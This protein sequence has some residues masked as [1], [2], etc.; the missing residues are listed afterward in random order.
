MHTVH[1]PHPPIAPAP[2]K[3]KNARDETDFVLYE[4]NEDSKL[5][6]VS[7]TRIG[8]PGAPPAAAVGIMDCVGTCA[9]A[10]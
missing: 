3:A 6:T 1:N 9:T 5:A 2:K 7:G 10:L 4:I 8:C